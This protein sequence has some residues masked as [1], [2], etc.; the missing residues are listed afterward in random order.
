MAADPAQEQDTDDGPTTPATIEVLDVT[1]LAGRGRLMGTARVELVIGGVSVLLQ[2]VR[3]VRRADGLTS[4]EPPSVRHVDGDLIP[5]V[6]LP[7]ELEDAIAREVLQ[8]A[9]GRVVVAV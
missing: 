7:Q 4:V 3:L 9:G 8:R 6:V 1:M 5:A 2:G